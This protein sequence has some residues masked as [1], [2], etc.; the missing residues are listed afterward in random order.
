MSSEYHTVRMLGC[1]HVEEGEDDVLLAF[2]EGICLL[3]FEI[4]KSPNKHDPRSPI[5]APAWISHEDVRHAC[6]GTTRRT[7]W[8]GEAASCT[9]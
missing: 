4:R 7:S 2:L 8:A 3:N 9:N 1:Y 5:R 6:V